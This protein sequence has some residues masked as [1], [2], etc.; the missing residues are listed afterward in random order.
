MPIASISA[1]CGL[2]LRPAAASLGGRNTSLNA[3]P[4]MAEST[5]VN[6][7]SLTV[8]HEVGEL[9]AGT[10][11]LTVSACATSSGLKRTCSRLPG[12]LRD[13]PYFAAPP[14]QAL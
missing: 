9:T 11:E 2:V 14:V 6:P 4:V 8:A 7:L 12:R 1:Y 5:Y 13:Q 10:T 3:P